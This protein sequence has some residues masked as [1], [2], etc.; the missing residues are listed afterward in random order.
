MSVTLGKGGM[1][2]AAGVQ[3]RGLEQDQG[4]GEMGSQQ[5]VGSRKL[6]KSVPG[7]GWLQMT[8]YAELN[9]D[10]LLPLVRMWRMLDL[11]SDGLALKG[12]PT[13]S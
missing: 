9:A 12:S 8:T 13:P 1:P 10:Y 4:G 11:I 7:W 5:G 2:G 3:A 6:L